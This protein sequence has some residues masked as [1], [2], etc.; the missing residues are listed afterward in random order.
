[1]SRI[2]VPK[3]KNPV[4]STNAAHC[5]KIKRPV[6]DAQQAITNRLG[7][8]KGSF[9]I[10]ASSQIPEAYVAF[11]RDC[12]LCQLDRIANTRRLLV[13]TLRHISFIGLDLCNCRQQPIEEK[14]TTSVS[15]PNIA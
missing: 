3:V 15:F 10:G 4:A 12:V 1:V 5:A 14:R 7:R 2:A 13:G 6:Q 9:A 8:A 11:Y